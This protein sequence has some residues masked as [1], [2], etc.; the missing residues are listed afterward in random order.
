MKKIS[1]DLEVKIVSADFQN[2]KGF[3]QFSFSLQRMNI[4]VGPN[5]CGKSTLIGAFRAL[6]VGLRKA[7]SKK[8]DT[9][10]RI[11]GRDCFVWSLPAETLSISTE[12]V[13]TDYSEVDSCIRFKLSNGNLLKLFF[14][15]D[16][17]IFLATETDGYPVMSPSQFCANFPISVSS[18]PIIGPV[19]HEE[20][21][22]K[23]ETVKK[24][25]GTHRSSRHF[26]NYWYYYPEGFQQFADLVAQTWPGMQIQPPKRAG[27]MS[28]K[29]VMWCLENRILRELYWAGY[30]FQV[31]CQ[32]LTHV[33]HS[34]KDTILLI[35]EPEVYLHPD[36]QRQLLSILREIG[37]DI[38]IAT[39]S[40]E[41]MSEADPSEIVLVDKHK[42]SAKH[43]RDIKEVQTALETIGSIQNITLTR[44][45]RNQKLLFVE[46]TYD[47]T[48]IRRFA[49]KLGYSALSLGNDITAVESGGFASISRVEAFAWGFQ[50]TA[51]VIPQIA[52]I[53][54]RDYFCAE[55]LE[56]YCSRLEK[57]IALC[58]FHNCK[59][60]E[61]YLL[62]ISPLQRAVEKSIHEKALRAGK[63]VEKMPDCL[64]IISQI[65]EEMKVSIQAQYLAKREEFFVRTGQNRATINEQTLR[66]F[67]DS[68][69]NIETR[70]S[71]LPG[72]E[73]LKA[74]RTEL[75]AKFGTSP[76][77]TKII[78]NFK[79][80]EIPADMV[81]LCTMLEQFR[82]TGTVKR[83]ELQYST[84]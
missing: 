77:D 5:N 11:D 2:Y 52:A 10:I 37:P 66:K 63:S 71:I 38:V 17:G 4:L 25:V 67:E 80:D 75:Q 70:I 28:S 78:E 62:C 31:W 51:D 74:L 39:H 44:L 21:I 26:R 36:V 22:L 41:I 15:K 19:E 46:G 60:I 9:R 69:K 68:W 3:G 23:E 54:D 76:T 34:A 13:H 12:N 43:L 72:K 84:T 83:T 61:N 45:A 47:F 1:P 7:A 81:E 24:D 29:L 14:S 73:T 6:A 53:F 20:E 64:A 79:K 57:S 32:L 59:E 27:G 48:I 30:G 42:R 49:R 8:P 55:E 16:G 50:K 18:A 33:S 40:S 82:R 65:S 58:H 35:D 56:V